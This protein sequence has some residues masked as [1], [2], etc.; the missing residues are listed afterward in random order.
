MN[1]SPKIMQ[2][3]NI[4]YIQI[5]SCVAYLIYSMYFNKTLQK[6][7]ERLSQKSLNLSNQSYFNNLSGDFLK[8]PEGLKL[9]NNYITK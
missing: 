8:S 9:L 1:F 5:S 6:M 7:H 3:T 2:I 4:D